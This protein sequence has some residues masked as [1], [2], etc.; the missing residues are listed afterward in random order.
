MENLEEKL[1]RY[2][3][4]IPYKEVQE[5]FKVFYETRDEKIREN[6][7]MRYMPVTKRIIERFEIREIEE[8]DLIQMAYEDLIHCIDI[9]NPYDKLLF[10][11]YF[12][13]RLFTKYRYI[14][15]VKPL[16]LSTLEVYSNENVED[17][18]ID[19][20]YKKE[21]ILLID[22][23]LANYHYQKHVE[24]FKML[25]G[26]NGNL[27]TKRKE[28]AKK[29]DISPEMVRQ[30]N[31]KI[32]IYLYKELTKISPLLPSKKIKDIMYLWNEHYDEELIFYEECNGLED[33]HEVYT[34]KLK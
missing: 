33:S 4:N 23:L 6:L 16:Q 13:Y 8:E 14:K 9:Y 27:I 3:E 29:F 20:E 30:I 11:V 2:R 5:A 28:V 26:L 19:S 32:L 25:Y 17:Q 1:L 15:E 31:N 7:I 22:K 34:R 24:V 10:Y 12:E 18:I 21:L